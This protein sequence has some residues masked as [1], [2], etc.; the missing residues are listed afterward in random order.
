MLIHFPNVYEGAEG[1]LSAE[2]GELSKIV[3]C[4]S[5]IG[6]VVIRIYKLFKKTQVMSAV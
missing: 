6:E 4:S 1:K 2:K 3:L 5:S